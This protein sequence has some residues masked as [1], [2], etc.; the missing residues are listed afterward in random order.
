MKSL[1]FLFASCLLF[2]SG[3]FAQIQ[4][5]SHI[6]DQSEDW[7]IFVDAADMD[8]GSPPGEVVRRS[9]VVAGDTR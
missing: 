4:F 1:Y 3:L 5:T 2:V 6:I 8:S 9:L 7:A